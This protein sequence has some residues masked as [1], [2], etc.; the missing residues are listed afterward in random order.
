MPKEPEDRLTRFD[1]FAELDLFSGW[2]PFRDWRRSPGRLGRLLGESGGAMRREGLAPA[3]DIAE[4]DERYVVTVELPGTK[5]ED[6]TIEM[7]GSALTIRGEKRNER[8]GRKEHHRWVERSYGSFSRSFTLPADA[9]GDRI[10]AE[11]REGVLTIE[12]PKA[13]GA[14]SRVISI[15]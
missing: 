6:I 3:V 11:F 13:D 12:I 15:E 2:S 14:R 4:D 10:K 8:G 1:P 5:K 9:V 7:R